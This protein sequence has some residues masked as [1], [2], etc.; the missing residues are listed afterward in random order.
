MAR[1]CRVTVQDSDYHNDSVDSCLSRSTSGRASVLQL[2]PPHAGFNRLVRDLSCRED[3]K[4]ARR[5]MK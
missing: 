4:L 2:S 5:E 1:T 3:C